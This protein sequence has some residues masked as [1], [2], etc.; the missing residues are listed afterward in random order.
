MKVPFK[1]VI[2]DSIIGKNRYIASRVQFRNAMLRG[3]VSIIAFVVGL[4]FTVIDVL[5]EVQGNFVWYAGIMGL[6]LFVFWLNRIHQYTWSSITLILLSNGIIYLFASSESA[7]SGVFFFFLA[8]GLCTLVLFGYKNRNLGFLLAGVSYVLAITAYLGILPIRA[9]V[10]YS[11]E[12]IKINFIASLTIAYLISILTIYFSIQLHHDIEANLRTSEQSLLLTSE[13]LKR[14]RERFQMA[15]EGSRAAIYEW[16]KQTGSIYL[17]PH[18]KR[19][20]GYGIDDLNEL[21]LQDFFE[22]IHPDDLQ[23][24]SN[25]FQKHLRTRAP[26]QS[27]LRLRTKDGSYKWVSDCGMSKFNERGEQVLIVGSIIDI[28]ERKMA[29]QQIRLQNDLLAKANEELDRCVYSA[30]HD[31]RAP[32]SSL[33]GLISVAEKTGNTEEIM[34]CLDMMKKRVL[35]MENFIREITDYSRNSRLG[36]DLKE[37]NV[38]KLVQ[39]I[40]E[41]LR[42]TNGAE[43]IKV[44]L[45]VLPELEFLTDANRLKVIVNNL[46]ANAIKY[47]D[48]AKED[49]FI[50]VTAKQ[51]VDQ[52]ILS[53][54]DNGT[55][56]GCEHQEKI[57]NM[58]YRASEKSE[59]SGLGLYIVKETLTK[60]TGKI[61]V[62]SQRGEGSTFVISLPL[63]PIEV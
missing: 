15:V 16:N 46:V 40:V 31:L 37:V 33:M 30:S 17:A 49:P 59:G 9:Y 6:A 43:R 12:Y 7:A 63:H 62:Q 21:N 1:K 23:R 10:D 44:N 47:H 2:R 19:L 13:E 54:K 5:T 11:A 48:H 57:F 35:T 58:F 28:D 3:L 32:L 26:Y 52:Y 20:L 45:N 14:S 51:D 53:V 36:I 34:L 41:S 29:E 24:I 38:R 56:I 42:F 27:E 18:Y 39:G 55:G 4:I 8:T 50:E 60:L 61:T 25:S 22:L